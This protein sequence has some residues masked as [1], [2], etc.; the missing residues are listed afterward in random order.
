MQYRPLGNSGQTISE[1]GLGCWQ[2]GGDFG[3]IEED[4][5][6][7]ILEAA[8]ESGIRFLDTADVYGG[9]RSE[10]LIGRFLKGRS[11]SYFLATKVGRGAGLYPDGYTEKSV[12]ESIEGSMERLGVSKLDL[13]QLHCVPT[14]VL[15]EGRI[16]DWLRKFQAEGLIRHFGASVESI[17]EGHIC[18]Q[19][20]GLS[21]LQVIF[22][23]F[24]QKPLVELFPAAISA[25]VGII[26]R[27]PLASGLLAGKYTRHH[28]FD[29]SDHRHYNRDGA[30]FNVGE[31][32]AGL[33]F[34]KG[35]ELAEALREFVPEG[36]NMAQW[37]QRWILDHPAVSTVITGASS[38]RQ[39]QNNAAV[40]EMPALEP[41][42]HATLAD[43][44]Q[45]SVE[46]HIR[47]PY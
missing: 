38:V 10:S 33:P 34:E 40:S 29:E 27:L 24:R 17:E 16:F 5:V 45:E 1:I 30:A 28:Q 26:V 4:R 20:E 19:Q 6:Q 9:G 11:E 13:I 39:V 8:E 32:F 22:N 36:H 35:V 47:G 18:L 44:Y 15:G 3:P 31:T 46:E 2:F 21:S 23:L 7:G 37:S 42:V 25:G 43:F 12:R 14:E 41:E